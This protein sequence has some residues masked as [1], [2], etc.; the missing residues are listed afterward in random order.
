[1]KS[2]LASLIYNKALDILSK[3]PENENKTSL[4]MLVDYVINRKR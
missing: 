2:E 1:M 4:K 3:F